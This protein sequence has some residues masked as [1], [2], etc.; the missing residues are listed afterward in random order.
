MPKSFVRK[1]PTLSLSGLTSTDDMAL[2]RTVKNTLEK[3][4]CEAAPYSDMLHSPSKNTASGVHQNVFHDSDVDVTQDICLGTQPALV[5]CPRFADLVRALPAFKVDTDG[6]SRNCKALDMPCLQPSSASHHSSLYLDLATCTSRK[7]YHHDV[8]SPDG[9]VDENTATSIEIAIDE[10]S[11]ECYLRP[12]AANQTVANHGNIATLPPTTEVSNP[13]ACAAPL[14]LEGMELDKIFEQGATDLD[15]GGEEMGNAG[16]TQGEPTVW[17]IP[18]SVTPKTPKISYSILQA[19]GQVYVTDNSLGSCNGDQDAD[20]S[21]HT[22]PMPASFMPKEVT[23]FP[24]EIIRT[25]NLEIHRIRSE[26]IEGR[27]CV[28]G[29]DEDI[30]NDMAARTVADRQCD[31]PDNIVELAVRYNHNFMRLWA[32]SWWIFE[33]DDAHVSEGAGAITGWEVRQQILRLPENERR[34]NLEESTTRLDLL[35]GT[36]GGIV[37]PHLKWLTKTDDDCHNNS[38][39][40]GASSP[41]SECH[42]L[43]FLGRWCHEK[44]NT[45][46][47]ISAFAAVTAMR[48]QSVNE[49]VCHKAVVLSQAHKRI[50][51][52]EFD[53]NIFEIDNECKGTALRAFATGRTTVAYEPCGSWQGDAYDEDDDLPVVATATCVDINTCAPNGQKNFY[54]GL[55]QPYVMPR[56]NLDSI[57]N[58]DDSHLRLPDP[59]AKGLMR[60][61]PSKLRQVQSV[62]YEDDAMPE[63]AVTKPKE[64]ADI[65]VQEETTSSA[66]VNEAAMTKSQEVLGNSP[67]IVTPTLST[68]SESEISEADNTYVETPSM[69]AVSGP[70]FNDDDILGVGSAFDDPNLEVNLAAWDHSVDSRSVETGSSDAQRQGTEAELAFI[71]EMRAKVLNGEAFMEDFAIAVIE[72]FGEPLAPGS[73]DLDSGEVACTTVCTSQ[74]RSESPYINVLSSDKEILAQ[75]VKNRLTRSSDLNE[76]AVETEMAISSSE[77]VGDSILEMPLQVSL[78]PC[79]VLSNIQGRQPDAQSIQ[80]IAWKSFHLSRKNKPSKL[81]QT[82][83]LA[84]PA[85][86]GDLDKT[87][88]VDNTGAQESGDGDQPA[89]TATAGNRVIK[90]DI[91]S[92]GSSAE[93]SPTSLGEFSPTTTPSSIAGEEEEMGEAEKADGTSDVTSPSPATVALVGKHRETR[94]NLGNGEVYETLAFPAAE[95]RLVEEETRATR[96]SIAVLPDAEVTCEDAPQP[97]TSLTVHPVAAGLLSLIAA[98][99][100]LEAEM[101]V[102][103]LPDVAFAAGDVLEAEDSSGIGY[104][105]IPESVCRSDSNY[106]FIWDA[107][108]VVGHAASALGGWVKKS[109][110]T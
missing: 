21:L 82:F 45:S 28:P 15:D 13:E 38:R 53:G 92:R 70:S 74:G 59:K 75:E 64:A 89:E 72:L 91:F 80:F 86:A 76:R 60:H 36:L 108:I 103:L 32:E 57:P 88:A 106:G 34:P 68:S 101:A 95:A 105:V 93:V 18:P 25:F 37:E 109:F 61:G 42:H 43:N 7:S 8:P 99:D 94:E 90:D 29:Q 81:L 41:E 47:V 98:G 63:I 56:Y 77:S 96:T 5:S 67:L 107:S 58:D 44:S 54:Y 14:C 16:S 24:T 10:A 55:Q 62:Q 6:I 78:K 26:G 110:F 102:D 49:S 66:T 52:F 87:E 73:S 35:V 19:E 83:H 11:G 50:D 97:C 40:L 33:K 12:A 48:K 3:A 51:P 85:I 69:D 79:Q 9:A 71:D 31:A 20:T 65:D 46:A 27:L 1:A 23:P 84:S 39:Y 2:L 22:S 17:S 4:D 100:A 104:N 30:V